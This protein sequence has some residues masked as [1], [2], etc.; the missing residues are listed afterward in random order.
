M[1]WFARFFSAIKHNFWRYIFFVALVLQI[2]YYLLGCSA[3]FW[4]LNFP[5]NYL[6]FTH[7]LRTIH[8]QFT[9]NKR[10]IPIAFTAVCRPIEMLIMSPAPAFS[11][12]I[13]KVK[14]QNLWF[15]LH[16]PFFFTTFAARIVCLKKG[17]LIDG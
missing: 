2:D 9:H 10:T 17:M 3:Y 13:N 15:Y 4:L 5:A 6:S 8:G 11:R 1:L 7:N 14:K 16:I 12:F